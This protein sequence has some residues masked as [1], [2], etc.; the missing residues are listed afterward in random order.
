[1]EGE[2]RLGSP[3]MR[4]FGGGGKEEVVVEVQGTSRVGN[5]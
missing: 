2:R 1:M 5:E 4:R 3:E